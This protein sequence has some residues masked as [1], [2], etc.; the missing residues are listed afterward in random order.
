MQVRRRRTGEVGDDVDQ[1]VGISLSS[2]TTWVWDRPR[3]LLL[4]PIDWLA[5]TREIPDI[6]EKLSAATIAFVSSSEPGI[7]RTLT[8]DLRIGG[9]MQVG[10]V[11]V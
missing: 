8:L 4:R 9:P 6:G 7:V 5:Q 2:G 10:R 11:C 3:V 1:W